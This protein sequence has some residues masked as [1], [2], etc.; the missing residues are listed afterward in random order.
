MDLIKKVKKEN[1]WSL[2]FSFQSG[3]LTRCMIFFSHIEQK[4]LNLCCIDVHLGERIRIWKSKN[5]TRT[6]KL[7]R[8]RQ[9]NDGHKNHF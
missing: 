3:K 9:C 1:A 7:R 2:V 8:R 6:I 5:Y 4:L